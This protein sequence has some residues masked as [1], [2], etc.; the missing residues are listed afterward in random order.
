MGLPLNQPAIRPLRAPRAAG[1]RRAVAAL[2]AHT[3]AAP[4]LAALAAALTLA[5]ITLAARPAAAAEPLDDYRRVEMRVPPAFTADCRARA[6]LVD[7]RV[8]AMP[9]EFPALMYGLRGGAVAAVTVTPSRDGGATIRFALK[10]PELRLQQAVIEKPRR[11]VV[12]VG[13]PLVL[14]GPVQE[15]LPFRPYP[16]TTGD[17]GVTLP[18]ANIQPLPPRSE[19]AQQY[20]ACHAA[21]VEERY[22]DAITTCAAVDADAPDQAPGRMAQKVIAEAHVK[23]FAAGAGDDLP[24]LIAALDA[25]E[26]VT[27]DPVERVRYPLLAAQTY[28]A[29]SDLNRAELHLDNRLAAYAGTPAEPFLL[30]ARARMLMKV[31]D[32]PKARAVLEDLRRLPGDAPTIGRAIIALAGLAYEE[33]AFV[34]AAGLFDLARQR[35]PAE[36]DSQPPAL[37]QSAEL[38]LLFDRVE[39]A[40]R[41]Y[42]LF[43]EK[44]P[45]A[46]P[47]WIA[48]IRLAEILSYTR[49]DLARD[50]FRELAATLDVREGQDLAFLRHAQLIEEPAVRRRLINDLSRDKRS[51]Y[52]LEEL[53]VRTMQQ[54]LDEGRIDD[55]WRLGARYWRGE[56]PP[57][58]DDAPLL[59]DRV[60]LLAVRAA[61]DPIEVLRLY[62][63][64]RERFEKHTLRGEVHLLVGRALRALAMWAE[65]RRVLQ[66]GLGGTTAEREPDAAARLYKELAAVL[67]EAEDRF[68]LGEIIEYLDARHPRR[69]DDFDYWMAKAHDAWWSGRAP[70]ARDMLVYAINGPLST[71]ERLRMMDALVELYAETG[72]PER[73]LAVL[74]SRVALHD[75]EGLPRAATGRRDARW[76]IAEIEIAR[77]QPGPALAALLVFLDEYPDDPDR[78]EARFQAGRALLALGDAPAARRQWDLV[79]K[80]DADGLFGKLARMELELLRWRERQLGP[81]T[82]ELGYSAPS[83]P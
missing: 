44:S 43:L 26:K 66:D 72:D 54:A 42:T 61:D 35:W 63:G 34:V 58:L 55:A 10:R 19:A 1:A 25:A 17:L 74:Q 53:T 83:S 14:M 32:L 4:A 40:E 5:A 46:P 37:F 31:G 64:D 16:M 30:A 62:Y 71:D 12:E 59:F 77:E 47:H 13:L 73:A 50:R 33:K 39:D 68:R 36:L 67:W 75:A 21:W 78:L 15:Q 27:R 3:L 9:A 70:L 49:P 57:L 11:W 6:E 18:A 65:A 81:L 41:N 8:S 2:A 24:G 38:S 69:F 48:R 45:A 22:A 80:A 76:R 60:L 79:A 7:C 23:R 29:Q 28:E 51:P 82:D 56:A 52:V 20:A